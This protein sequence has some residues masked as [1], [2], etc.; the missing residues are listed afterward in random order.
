MGMSIGMKDIPGALLDASE[1][2]AIL[3]V[4]VPALRALV[5]AL[6]P[7]KVSGQLTSSKNPQIEIKVRARRSA[8]ITGGG[9]IVAKKRVGWCVG[10]RYLGLGFGR[11]KFALSD[12]LN[13]S[14]NKDSKPCEVFETL[15]TVRDIA[16]MANVKLTPPIRP[17]A[18]YDGSRFAVVGHRIRWSAR[19]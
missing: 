17:Y 9:V 18:T 10:T 1:V 3:A 12:P 11:K 15:E 19:R 16:R 7:L 8:S 6:R 14:L 13:Q 4:V 5:S 2:A